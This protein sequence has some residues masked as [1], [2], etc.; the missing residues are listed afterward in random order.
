M[1]FFININ[2]NQGTLK[3]KFKI[4]KLLTLSYLLSKL[5]WYL[6]IYI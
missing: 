4:E 6:L 1:K 2:L 3:W 5:L